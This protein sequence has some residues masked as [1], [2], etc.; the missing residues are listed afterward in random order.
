MTH[1][2]LPAITLLVYHVP[3]IFSLIVI[4]G[5][6][7]ALLI[8]FSIKPNVYFAH[9]FLG[10]NALNAIIDLVSAVGSTTQLGLMEFAFVTES[11]YRMVLAL[12]VQSSLI[13]N[14]K[15]AIIPTA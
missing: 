2:A 6:A 15:R 11:C 4:G 12:H 7:V 3:Q 8:D 9:L 1:F 14:A 13:L 5:T 10:H